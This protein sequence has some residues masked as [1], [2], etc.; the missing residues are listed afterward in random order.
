MSSSFTISGD[1]PLAESRADQR[2]VLVTGAAGNI[3]SYFA[4]H[5]HQKYEL[6]LLVLESDDPS[7]IQSFGEVVTGDIRDLVRMRELCQGIDTVVHLA[8]DPDPSALWSNLLPLNI[9][10]TYNTFVAAKAAG[11]RRVLFASSIHAVSG[12]PPGRQ[13]RT[14][15]PVNPAD[16]YGV[17]KCFGEALGRYMA[18]QEGLSVIAIR[19]GWFQ[20]HSSAQRESGI[21]MI[22]SWVSRRDLHQLIERSIDVENLQF[23]I[24]HGLSNNQF[25]RLDISDAQLLLG[26]APLD[27]LMREQPELK[28][29]NLSERLA[30]TD[31]DVQSG[32]REDL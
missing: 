6:R 3:G 18:E 11:C 12:Y 8:A 7:N 9:E 1:T 15:D 24:F 5:A 30:E 31:T 13:V 10:G 25:K 19:I 29:L 16:L 26:Y 32:I 14:S 23:A 4:E 17:T 2:R 20:P 21:Q 22:D 27:D 28:E